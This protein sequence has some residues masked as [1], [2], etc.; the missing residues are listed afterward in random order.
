MGGLNGS[1]G[2]SL[3]GVGCGIELQRAMG[4]IAVVAVVGAD[5]IHDGYVREEVVWGI[6]WLG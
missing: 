5:A 1:I 3:E 6:V 2:H 4:A